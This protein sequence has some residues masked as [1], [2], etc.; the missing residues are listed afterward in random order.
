MC[1]ATVNMIPTGPKTALLPYA[2]ASP[3]FAVW[4]LP[5]NFAASPKF[6]SIHRMPVGIIDYG[7]P[8]V[9]RPMDTDR[10]VTLPGVRKGLIFDP[11]ES[12]VFRDPL[13]STAE[14]FGDPRVSWHPDMIVLRGDKRIVERGDN[15]IDIDNGDYPPADVSLVMKF[16]K[17]VKSHADDRMQWR[18]GKNGQLAHV[19]LAKRRLWIPVRTD[20][21]ESKFFFRKRDIPALLFVARVKHG[22]RDVV[23]RAIIELRS[24]TNRL[25]DRSPPWLQLKVWAARELSIDLS[26]FESFMREIL[27]Q[28]HIKDF[29][30]KTFR[31]DGIV[32]G[33]VPKS[34]ESSSLDVSATGPLDVTD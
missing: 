3:A 22:S 2:G 19:S 10:Y 14:R 25:N 7:V 6:G 31:R 34:R 27:E 26:K 29:F 24:Q 1:Y 4:G 13:R 15:F 28:G 18:S 17:F 20:S 12:R 5:T 23:R 11:G 9:D 33:M 21:R 16:M 32:E 30:F 8:I